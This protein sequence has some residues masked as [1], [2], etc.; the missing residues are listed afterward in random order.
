MLASMQKVVPGLFCLLTTL[1][2]APSCC[3]WSFAKSLDGPIKALSA[4]AAFL[5]AA[6]EALDIFGVAVMPEMA[7][8]SRIAKSQS[9]LPVRVK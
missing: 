4:A 5:H 2:S 8:Q 9:L 6:Q 3:D 1:Q 7:S